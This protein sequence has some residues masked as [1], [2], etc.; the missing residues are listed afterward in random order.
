M[1]HL[2]IMVSQ[3]TALICYLADLL[4]QTPPTHHP[5]TQTMAHQARSGRVLDSNGADEPS[6]AW[7]DASEALLVSA[8]HAHGML[9]VQLLSQPLNCCSALCLGSPANCRPSTLLNH[10]MWPAVWC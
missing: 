4:L 5:P 2:D 6:S 3:W 8:G 10:L 9:W 1:D 7:S